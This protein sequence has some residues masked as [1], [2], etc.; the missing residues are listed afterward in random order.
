MTLNKSLT[1]EL[2]WFNIDKLMSDLC[3]VRIYADLEIKILNKFQIIWVLMNFEVF[4]NYMLQMFLIKNRW[5]DIEFLKKI[6]YV[7]N[8]MIHCYEIINI[9]YMIKNF[10]KTFRSEVMSF[11]AVNMIK[12]DFILE[13]SWLITHNSIVNW[14]M[15][16]WYY[17]LVNDW[18]MIEEFKIFMQSIQNEE[19]L[20]W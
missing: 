19:T 16:S 9:D 20:F 14:N 5:K 10:K 7:N 3:Q 8:E 2:M 18:I 13:I 1:L 15:K 17:Y 4:V 11:H 12:H 6:Q